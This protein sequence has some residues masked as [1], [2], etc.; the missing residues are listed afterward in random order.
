[1]DGF[2]VSADIFF[3]IFFN[4]ASKKR[5]R[6]DECELIFESVIVLAVLMANIEY[7]REAATVEGFALREE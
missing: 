4:I 3:H 6:Y 7:D 5:R 1:M 2:I